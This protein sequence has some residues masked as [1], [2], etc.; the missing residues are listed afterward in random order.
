MGVLDDMTRLRDN[1][2]AFNVGDANVETRILADCV[3]CSF[4]Y[5]VRRCLVVL[6]HSSDEGVKRKILQPSVM[7]VLDEPTTQDVVDYLK[8]VDEEHRAEWGVK[9]EADRKKR[10]ALRRQQEAAAAVIAEQLQREQEEYEEL[11]AAEPKATYEDQLDWGIDL[12][13]DPYGPP[14][15]GGKGGGKGGRVPPVLRRN[16]W[17]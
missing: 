10:E 9:Q 7:P 16:G 14:C 15:G 11:M 12:V 6:Q 3:A 2:R 4:R 5:L 1:A 13:D 17:A 8:V